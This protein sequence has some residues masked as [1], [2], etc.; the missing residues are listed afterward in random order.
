M[1]NLKERFE[2]CLE[3][4]VG[5]EETRLLTP[6]VIHYRLAQVFQRKTVHGT[7]RYPHNNGVILIAER[8]NASGESVAH[9]LAFT[10]SHGK[11]ADVVAQFSSVLWEAW[12]KLNKYGRVIPYR[13]T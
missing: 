12:Q 4:L 11:S 5:Y 3:S 2:A 8:H 6:E 9:F 7:L 10:N 1:Q 13:S